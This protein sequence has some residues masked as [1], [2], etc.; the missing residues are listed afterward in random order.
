MVNEIKSQLDH[1]C[2]LSFQEDEL[3]WMQKTLPWL[4]FDYIEFLRMWRPR[5]SEIRINEADMQPAE[6]GLAI[7]V[8]GTWLNT[9][10]HEMPIL[11]IV[12]EVYFAFKDGAAGA[13]DA[14]FQMKT[15]K[16]A[17]ELKSGKIYLPAFSEFG[18]RRRYS[19]EIDAGLGGEMLQGA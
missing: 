15:L 14:E 7:E 16:K 4:S 17:D 6:C 9:M 13:R 11:S 12:N 2:T 10:M 18:L 1:Y 5:R 8:V 19:G 3:E